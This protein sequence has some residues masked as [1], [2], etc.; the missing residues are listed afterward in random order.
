M[1]DIQALKEKYDFYTKKAEKVQARL[2]RLGVKYPD[3][4]DIHIIPSVEIGDIISNAPN[5]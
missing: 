2:Q 1:P 4:Q 5:H 3:V